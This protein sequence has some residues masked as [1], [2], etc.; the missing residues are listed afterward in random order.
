M[1][2]KLVEVNRCAGPA[3]VDSEQDV[4]LVVSNGLDCISNGKTGLMRFMN[5]SIA[6][7][8]SRNR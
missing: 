4:P 3:V 7:S 5:Q 2:E 8:S 1:Q 6:R